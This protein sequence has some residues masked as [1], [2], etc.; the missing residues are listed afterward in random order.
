[1]EGRFLSD[2]AFH[3]KTAYQNSCSSPATCS[4][5]G[6]SSVAGWEHAHIHSCCDAFACSQSTVI[7][8]LNTHST[9]DYYSPGLWHAR[10]SGLCH[11]YSSFWQCKD[12]AGSFPSGS[13]SCGGFRR[14]VPRFWS[15][16]V[17][18]ILHIFVTDSL[19]LHSSLFRQDPWEP[20]TQCF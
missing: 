19:Q 9:W 14:D 3:S 12:F 2:S 17:F 8:S 5:S 15:V 10:H 4:D 11:L 16:Q 6:F 1:M 7:C 18:S 13:I 20:G